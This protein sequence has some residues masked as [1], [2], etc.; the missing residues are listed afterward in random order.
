[1]S[2]ADLNRR[3]NTMSRTIRTK[4]YKFNELSEDA[5]RKAIES[6]NDV[7]EFTANGKQF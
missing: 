7:N 5:K 2:V 1:M 6:F 4:V 3:T